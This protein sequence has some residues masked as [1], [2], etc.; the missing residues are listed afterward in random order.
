[1]VDEGGFITC[2]A[3]SWNGGWLKN[4]GEYGIGIIF[5]GVPGIAI[6]YDN[7]IPEGNGRILSPG[8]DSKKSVRNPIGGG[9]WSI[10]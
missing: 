4:K 8:E 10:A 6:G 2:F 3:S 9:N 1:M 7:S 5:V